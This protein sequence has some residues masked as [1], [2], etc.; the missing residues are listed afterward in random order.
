MFAWIVWQ[1]VYIPFN[2]CFNQDLANPSDGI[3]IFDYFQDICFGI[4]II[5]NFNTGFYKNGVLILNRKLIVI[6]YLK[7]WFIL[8]L[9]STVP[10]SD[11]V[12]YAMNSSQIDDYDYKHSKTPQLLRLFRILRFLR[13]LKL[14]RV[15]KLSS[16]KQKY[17]DLIYND[18]VGV[19]SGII[20]IL[21]L[22]LFTTHTFA[23]IFW[24]IGYNTSST[25]PSSWVI[26]KGLL[27]E[28]IVTQYITSMYWAFTTL[29]SLGYGDISAQ[30]T[31]ERLVCMLSMI[32]FSWVYAFT[33]S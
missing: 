32:T 14:L 23:C 11:I 10:Y 15:L 18:N 2:L 29:V 28:D 7:S 17:E 27:D 4:D 16:L 26:V 20:R 30:N 21:I 24:L 3:T 22:I 33:L 19:L 31:D 25:N 13:F 1:A 12:Q 8:D 9:L 6:S 5:L